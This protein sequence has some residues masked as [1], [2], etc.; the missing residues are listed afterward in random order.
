VKRA[1]L[2]AQDKYRVKQKKNLQQSYK[3][4]T[5]EK[6]FLFKVKES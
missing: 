4:T 3:S 5:I 6:R 1:S 2:Y